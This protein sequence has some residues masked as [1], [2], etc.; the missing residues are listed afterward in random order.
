MFLQPDINAFV[1]VRMM[2]LQSFL[3]SKVLLSGSTLIEVRLMQL[4]KA[5]YLIL[6]TLFGIVIET[7]LPH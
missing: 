3:E 4:E 2:A 5:L 7:S 6:F 1:D